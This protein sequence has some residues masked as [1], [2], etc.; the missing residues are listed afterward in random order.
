MKKI[1]V[2][3]CPGSGK[4]TFTQALIGLVPNFY[5]GAYGG[6]VLVDGVNVN[7]V[8]TDDLCQK[9]GLVFQNPFNQVSGSKNTVY[10]EIAFGLENL[11]VPREE[12]DERIDCAL[13]DVSMS[14]YRDREPHM[15]SGGQKQRIAIAGILAM[16]PKVI[17]LD[18]ATAMLDPKGRQ[19]VMD[20]AEKL[21]KEM[22][23]TII[24]VTHHM[25]QALYSDRSIV[26]SDGQIVMDDTPINIFKDS[27][28]DELSLEVPEII[29]L[30]RGLDLSLDSFSY[31]EVWEHICRL[32]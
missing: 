20:I 24:H 14:E 25:E 8:K 6:C 18:E 23:I 30:M 21:N 3:G 31:E 22:G 11:G 5:R 16:R 9:I 12:M 28:I 17:L 19:E 29:K 15:L 26:V 7:D 4:S 13:G 1:I 32:K 27:R 2:I 10:E